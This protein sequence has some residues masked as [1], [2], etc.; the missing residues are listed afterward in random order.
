MA[1]PECLVAKQLA[2]ADASLVWIGGNLNKGLRTA[3]FGH[4]TVK[5]S[6][7]RYGWD[8]IGPRR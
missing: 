5:I 4:V 2:W 6:P 3:R 1:E 7:Y 8:C